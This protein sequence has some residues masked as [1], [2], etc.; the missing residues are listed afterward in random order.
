MSVNEIMSKRVVSV[1]MDDSLHT[2]KEL[3]EATGFH[4]LLVVEGKKLVGVISDRDLL[5]S[6]SPFIDTLS[7]RTKDRATLERRAHQ[8]MSRDIVA[9]KEHSS[10]ITAIAF[11]NRRTVSCLPVINQAGE[12]VGILSWRDI[13]QYMEEMVLKKK[14]L[15]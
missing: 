12:P 3:F 1:R 10:I 4:H 2:L 6:L 5:K 9:I 13:L 8:I 14:T 7:E 11:F 15:S